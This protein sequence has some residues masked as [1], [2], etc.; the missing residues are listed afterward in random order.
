MTKLLIQHGP[1]KGQKIQVALENKNSEGVIFAPREETIEAITSYCNSI[2]NLNKDNTYIDPQFY[3]STYNKELAK[4]LDSQFNYPIEISRRDCRKNKEMI[5]EYF[6]KYVDAI[7]PITNNVITPGFSIEAIDWKFDYSIDFYDDFK[8]RYD[9][10]KYY[11]SLMLSAKIFHSKNDTEDILEDLK[12]NIDQN[13]GI[14]LIINHIPSQ[15]N[16]YDSLDPETLSNILYFIY[17]LKQE[18]IDIIVG[19]TFL[20][21]VL[22]AMLDCEAVSSGWFNK[23]RKFDSNRFDDVDKYG[24]RKKRYTSTSSLTYMTIEL[25]KEFKDDIDI[26]ILYSKTACDEKALEDEDNVSFV[27][28]EH[29]YWEALSN[30]LSEINKEETLV[31]KIKFVKNRIS[32]SREILEKIMNVTQNK[33]IVQDKVKNA[34]KHID[35]WGFAIELFEKKASLIL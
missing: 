16:N 31:D 23:L 14:Y 2:P 9:F 32:I 6:D 35:D 17:T 27:D 33:E 24:K 8:K 18:N 29:Q 11:L 34:F 19:Y 22:Y 25:I 21:S 15:D 1:A 4:L 28:L 10:K 7:K 13:D 20:N 5:Y 12:E 30:I 26:S 3:Y